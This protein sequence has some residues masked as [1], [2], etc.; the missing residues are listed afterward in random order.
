VVVGLEGFE[1]EVWKLL[2]ADDDSEALV[3]AYSGGQ[4]WNVESH[5]TM[6]LS[7]ICEAPT[8]S[9]VRS[10]MDLSSVVDFGD[11]VA[12]ARCGDMCTIGRYSMRGLDAL[13]LW[14]GAPNSGFMPCC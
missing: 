1:D 7:K 14:D 10:L 13:N 5:E 3:E 2:E 6:R 8:E 11:C 12:R 9:E 4:Y